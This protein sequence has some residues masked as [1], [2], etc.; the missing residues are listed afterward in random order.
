[1]PKVT[2]S[3]AMLYKDVPVERN[4]ADVSMSTGNQRLTR[5][6]LRSSAIETDLQ[7][8]EL[9]RQQIVAVRSSSSGSTNGTTAIDTVGSVSDDEVNKDGTKNDLGYLSSVSSTNNGTEPKSG[10]MAE[11]NEPRDHDNEEVELN[12]LHFL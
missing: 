4:P 5:R 11:N 9:Q 10:T 2:T 12:N 1:M 6:S 7:I 8:A 3:D